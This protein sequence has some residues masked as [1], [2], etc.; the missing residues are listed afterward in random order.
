MTFTK[1]WQNIFGSAHVKLM[2]LKIV[3]SKNTVTE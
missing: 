2:E 3:A 1:Q